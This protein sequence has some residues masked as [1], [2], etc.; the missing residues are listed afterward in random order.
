MG[1]GPL[2]PR[3]FGG[4]D[5]SSEAL[6]RA[7]SALD[8]GRPQEAER[9]AAELLEA[10]P[11]HGRALYLRGSALV[12][13]DRA[14]EAIVSL[15]AAARG[16]HDAENDTMLAIALRQAGRNE[17]ALR[18]LKLAAKRR[19]PYAVAFKE[20]GFLLVSMGRYEEA[21]E[22]LNRGI[23][24]APMMPQLSIQLGYVHF[25]R[26]NFADART[27]FARALEIL[28][29]APD[30]LFGMARAHQEV[31]KNEPAVEYFRRY[32]VRTP[33]DQTAWLQLGNCL[34]ELGQLDAGYDCFRTAAR[35]DVRRY[36]NA[37]RSLAAAAR[38]RFWLRPSD[39][40]RFL[41]GTKG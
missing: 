29:D 22:A 17:D 2:H 35:G 21:I 19:P 33:G 3:A 34:L 7:M 38:G 6:Q 16:R 32:L 28:P 18:R 8:G 4:S 39:A 1:D 36:G 26:R 9:I 13:Q 12:M 41:R 27:A 10:D 15:E 24:I 5:R 11:H 25:S 40:A 30:A 23:E 37:L 31:G 14:A 20:L